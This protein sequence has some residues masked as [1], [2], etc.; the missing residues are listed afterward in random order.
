MMSLVRLQILI[1]LGET[2]FLI[3]VAFILLMIFYL[4]WSYS[5]TQAK[6]ISQLKSELADVSKDKM[7]LL[8]ELKQEERRTESRLHREALRE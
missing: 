6:L 2:T 5:F 7:V 4:V 3:P 8:E 1:F